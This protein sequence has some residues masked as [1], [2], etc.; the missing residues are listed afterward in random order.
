MGLNKPITVSGGLTAAEVQSIIDAQT[1]AISG[2]VDAQTNTLKTDIPSSISGGASVDDVKAA[3]DEKLSQYQNVAVVKSIQRGVG[4]LASLVIS[5]VNAGKSILLIDGIVT[6]SK[7]KS[8]D[9]K[10]TTSEYADYPYSDYAWGNSV[11]GATLASLED[12]KVTISNV[13][14]TYSWQLVEFY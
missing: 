10:Y 4:T 6:T 9:T 14:N 13:K 12:N 8:N 5:P 11:G 3:L 1:T 2:K 7:V